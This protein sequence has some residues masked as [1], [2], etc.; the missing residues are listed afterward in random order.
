MNPDRHD[1][2]PSYDVAAASGSS[3]KPPTTH[4]EV[5]KVR[6]GIPASARRSMED[7]QRQL[8]PGWV[9][10]FDSQSGHQFFVDTTANPPRSI[11]SHPYDDEKY[12]NSL[13]PAERRHIQSLHHPV[14][15]KADIEAESSE[16]DGNHHYPAPSNNMATMGGSGGPSNQG[17]LPPRP[18]SEQPHGLSGFGRKMKDKLTGSTH[19]QREASR[20][21]R[22]EEERRIYER[23]TQ[24]RIAMQRA[25]ETG[26]PQFIG[27]GRDGK[28]VYIEPPQ[29]AQMPPGAYGYNPYTQGP[30]AN[31]NA[32]F[33][34]PQYQY[35]RP[36]GMGYGGG[37]GMPLAGGLMGGMLL[38]SMMF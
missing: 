19:E 9:R 34:R 22:E 12:L 21:A 11:W 6:N 37:Y 8:P 26:Q 17:T 33:V 14:P 10:Q 1:Q 23:H 3:A 38:G 30:Y 36:Y 15:N 24:Y 27:K 16:D 18:Q 5:P 29:G 13:D 32:T 31:P 7:E 28:D 4:L 2:P 20:R 35:S 25:L